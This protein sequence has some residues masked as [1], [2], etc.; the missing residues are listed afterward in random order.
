MSNVTKQ[1]DL[2]YAVGTHYAGLMIDRALPFEI[3]NLFSKKAKMPKMKG[4]EFKV[5][6]FLPLDPALVALTEG[7]KPEGQRMTNIRK[8]VRVKQYG[9]Y[10]EITDWCDYTLEDPVLNES[11][12]LLGEQIGKTTDIL[13]RDVLAATA[14]KYTCQFGAVTAT[15]LS[16]KDIRR[17]VKIILENNGSF[18]NSMVEGVNKFGTAPLPETFWVLASVS[19]MDDLED[20]PKWR[21]KETYPNT[22]GVLPAEY[23]SIGFTRWVLS[24]LG[25]YNSVTSQYSAFVVSRDAYLTV[26]LTGNVSTHFK[27]FGSAGSLDPIDQIATHGWKIKGYGGLILQDML[28]TEMLMTHTA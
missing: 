24:S 6:G 26:D 15:D 22:K 28:M 8:S 9:D 17:V 7:T 27:D 19:M 11:T 23:G 5:G 20:L 10:V 12:K 3:H 25:Y 14:S 16:A 2:E 18:F 21:G 1:T 13:T 4:D